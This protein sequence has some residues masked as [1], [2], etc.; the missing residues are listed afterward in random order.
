MAA[1]AL[2]AE[3]VKAF[4]AD[5]A[6]VQELFEGAKDAP[7]LSSNAPPHAGAVAWVRGL[8]ARLAEPFA[9]LQG[10]EHGA[11]LEG[12]EGLAAAAACDKAMAEMEAFEAA[13]VAQWCQQVGRLGCRAPAASNTCLANAVRVVAFLLHDQTACHAAVV[14]ATTS[15]LSPPSSA[16]R[17][18]A[19]ARPS[20]T[21]RC[22][23]ST[24]TPRPTCRCWRSTLTPRSSRC[25][26]RRATSCC[27]RSGCRTLL[28]R[29]SSAP[30]CTALRS[31]AWSSWCGAFGGGRVQSACLLCSAGP[32]LLPIW[33]LSPL[34]C[35][36][37][38]TAIPVSRPPPH[39]VALYNRIQRT[40]LP[41]EKPLVEAKLSAVEAALQR[42]AHGRG[43][44]DTTR[45]MPNLP[46][47]AFCPAI[48]A[49][50]RKIKHR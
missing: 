21:S 28:R 1:C 40:I 33:A 27:C 37:V 26:A 13:V 46:A 30:T 20:S 31:A 43:R 49:P 10:M 5:V 45:L 29:C 8:K 19:R 34:L 47:V 2:Q 36:G 17:S 15:H 41:V 38:V 39:Q 42:Y 24:P 18:T 25:C 7:V 44:V 9:K 14:A 32:C 3:L 23:S 50:H 6:E 35:S 16:P 11:L 48:A 4:A 22:C 12:R